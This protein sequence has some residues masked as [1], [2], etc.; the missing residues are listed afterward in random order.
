MA[1][2]PSGKDLE[3][4][5]LNASFS[6]LSTYQVAGHSSQEMLES[7]RQ[8]GVS[9]AEIII[10]DEIFQLLLSVGMKRYDLTRAYQPVQLNP[11]GHCRHTGS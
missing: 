3:E 6:N 10:N 9:I 11:L 7:A 4:S 1:M 2:Y 5:R 8:L